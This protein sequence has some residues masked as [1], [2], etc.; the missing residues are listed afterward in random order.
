MVTAYD[1]PK[2]NKSVP[3]GC[4]LCGHGVCL[5]VEEGVRWGCMGRMKKRWKDGEKENG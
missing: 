5:C 2:L 4:D 3:G 1:V